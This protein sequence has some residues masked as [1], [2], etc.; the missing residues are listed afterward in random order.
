MILSCL[1]EGGTRQVAGWRRYSWQRGLGRKR[2]LPIRRS[3][4]ARGSGGF[5]AKLGISAALFLS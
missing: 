1:A 5:A 4:P 2:K 3:E